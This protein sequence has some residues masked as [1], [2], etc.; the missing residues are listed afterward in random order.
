M[1][2]VRSKIASLILLAGA[3][4]VVTSCEAKS[5]ENDPRPPVPTTLSISVTKSGITVTPEVIGKVGRLPVNISQNRTAPAS[6][7]DPRRGAVVDAR[8]SSLTGKPSRLFLEGPID[9]VKPIP[10]NG[11]TSF[12]AE[13]PNGIYRLSSPASRETVRFRVGP[14]RVSSATDVLT[15]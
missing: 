4:A 13:L 10:G 12:Q 15:P 14:S 9:E 3:A 8:V 5:H 1:R 6:Q 11:T 7:A 2:L